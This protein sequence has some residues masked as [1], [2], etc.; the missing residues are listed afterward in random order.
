[1]SPLTGKVA[2]V[3]GKR[4]AVSVRRLSVRPRET[5]G[6]LPMVVQQ[7]DPLPCLTSQAAHQ[8]RGAVW[9]PVGALARGRRTMPYVLDTQ[10]FLSQR[11]SRETLLLPG[12]KHR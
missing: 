12:E 3:T 7:A 6:P 8:S 5:V 9:P 4:M 10:E 11:A 1:M 2:I